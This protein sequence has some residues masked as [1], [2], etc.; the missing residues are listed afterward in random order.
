MWKK[1]AKELQYF[2]FGSNILHDTAYQRIKQKKKENEI[3]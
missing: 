3:K 2:L 1:E